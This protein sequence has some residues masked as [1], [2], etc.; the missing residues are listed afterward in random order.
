MRQGRLQAV[1]RVVIRENDTDI[2]QTIRETSEDADLVFLGI[3][4]PQEEEEPE[5][6][7][8]YYS[9]LLQRTR[10]YP[11]TALVL[12]CEDIQFNRIFE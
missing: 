12:A 11:P 6:Y 7:G 2:F 4:P 1:P 8:R 5:K 10:D 9:D 3:R